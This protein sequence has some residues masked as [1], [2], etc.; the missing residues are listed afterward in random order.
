MDRSAL[1]ATLKPLALDGT[2]I[3]FSALSWA[4]R[5]PGLDTRNQARKAWVSR[6]PEIKM[7]VLLARSPAD[8]QVL[9]TWVFGVVP[10]DLSLRGT[11]MSLD[12]RLLTVSFET[13]DS[14][15]S[16]SMAVG[17]SDPLGWGVRLQSGDA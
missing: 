10:S 4:V 6:T 17:L 5:P 12:M 11:D 16:E 3:S 15:G 2:T 8:K 13:A 1:T 7:G 9:T 14:D